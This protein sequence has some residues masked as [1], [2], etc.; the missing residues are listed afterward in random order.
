VAIARI[1]TPAAFDHRNEPFPPPFIETFPEINVVASV[2][3]GWQ[4][5]NI[6]KTQNTE[7]SVCPHW[8][9]A[10]HLI[11]H[12]YCHDESSDN[13]FSYFSRNRKDK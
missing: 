12:L 1:Q 11:I 9:K 6:I 13:V 8:A 5:L 2:A 10:R 4:R 7:A 3:I